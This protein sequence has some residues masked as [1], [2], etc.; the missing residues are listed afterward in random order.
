MRVLK[1]GGTSVGSADNIRQT[2]SIIKSYQE[3]YDTTIVVVSA[4]SGITNALIE[5][6]KKAAQQ[7]ETYK[8]I[9]TTIETKHL[10]TIRSLM[11]VSEQSSLIAQ[12]KVQLNEIDELLHGI[13]LIKELSK[14]VLDMLQSYGERMSSLI[15][16]TYLTQEGCPAKAEDARKFIRTDQTFGAAKV[17][18]SYTEDAI[19]TYF[20]GVD[21]TPI[22]TGFCASDHTGETTTLGRGGSDY[23][24]AIIGGALEAEEIEIWTDVDG[25][26]T[27]DP[28]I[29]KDAFS[30]DQISYE[31]A[32]EL[33][34]FGAKVIYPPTILPAL[35]K[36]IP[37]SIRN[38]FNPAY[39]GT[40]I[41]EESGNEELPIK[42]I[43]SIK[44][45][46]LLT[47]SGSG[48]I[49]IPGVSSRLFSALGN[50]NIN[51][52]LITQASS[53][54]SITLAVLPEFA[55]DA[56]E[57][58]TNEFS[59]EIERGKVDIVHVEE[60]LSVIAVVG[61]NMKH[62]P[63]ISG[64]FFSA[65][66]KN[67]INVAAIAQG[68]SELNI[69]VV[70]KNSDLKKALNALHEKFFE[71]D[72][73]TIHLY[74][75]GA[76]LIGS[77]LLNQIRQQ[78]EFLQND[79]KLKI[80]LAGLANSKLMKLD[81]KGLDIS[82]SK[83]EL[84][85]DAEPVDVAQF[86]DRVKAMN[87]RNS[88]IVDCTPT[89]AVVDHY[90]DILSNSISIT[91]PNKLANSGSLADYKRYQKAA[92]RR[93]VK[94]CY[95]TNVGAGLPVISPLNDLKYSGDQ[96]LKIEGILSGT[97]SYIFNSFDGSVPFA[98]VVRTAQEKGFTEPD[99]RDDLNGMDVA[100]KILILARE[101][102]YALEPS[103]VD[104]E[105]I[106]PQSCLDAQ[107]VD[108][109]YAE[110]ES[111]ADFFEN[112]REQA[113]NEGKVLRFIATLENGQASVNLEAV[114][115]SH[116]FY[117]LSGSDNMIAFTTKRY[118]NEPL[119]I[120]GPGAGAEVTAAGVFAE[121]ISIGNYL[122]NG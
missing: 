98:E 50:A 41:C 49:G 30:L 121:V 14:R 90:E 2:A 34:H 74:M 106:L 84:L 118:L 33:S 75:I 31:E 105:N 85:K 88:I 64:K 102:G 97:L 116:P 99:P 110:L 9:H 89:M 108:D 92:N 71:Q 43:S 46:H 78:T 113:A 11:E 51:V 122:V 7:D 96:I 44:E 21:Y 91:T 29:V 70:I 24:A 72:L 42:G 65:L 76:G 100:R 13:F 83:E 45:V 86:V 28:R 101:A 111:N 69:S 27:T 68:S 115:Q 112:R 119:I 73:N 22:V 18:Q 37:I 55:E 107:T 16:A 6:G 58:I 38:T 19:Q 120:K 61:E 23:T 5:A 81:E 66:G 95:E 94:F 47:L 17:N 82:L 8:E 60:S 62:T 104:V 67:G 4:M 48:L 1:F 20:A 54:H 15:I 10:D 77:T 87:M 57:A 103:D 80:R 35:E 36:K 53:E 117:H 25:I 12:L 63:G 39:P 109:F 79:Q 40:M 59:A 114:D 26:M 3:K 52:I 93:G 56:E 32:M